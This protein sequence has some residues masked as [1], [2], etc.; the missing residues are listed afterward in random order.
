MTQ[1]TRLDPS[2]LPAIIALHHRVIADLP[3]GNAATETDPL[4]PIHI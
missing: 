4:A 3:P 1:L 2:H